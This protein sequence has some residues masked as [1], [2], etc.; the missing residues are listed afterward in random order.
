MQPGRDEML[1][2]GRAGP[3]VPR[4]PT[5]IT[6]PGGPTRAPRTSP[7]SPRPSRCRPAAAI[8]RDARVAEGPEDQGPPDGL[9]LDQ[10]IEIYV[11][12]NLD[13]RPGPGAAPGPGGRAHG[14]PARQS[15]PLRRQPAHPVRQLQHGAAR[16]P[17]PVRPEHLASHRLFPQADRRGRSMPRS[18]L[19]VMEH[20]YQDAVRR[21][22][23]DLYLAY[24][25]V[26]AAR[27]TVHYCP[28]Q[29]PGDRRVPER[30]EALY[31]EATRMSCR[32]RAGPIESAIAAVSLTDAEEMLRRRSGS[33]R[34]CSTSPPDRRRSPRAARDARGAG[35]P[36]PPDEELIQHRAGMPPG[37][38]VVPA[39]RGGGEGLPEAR[40]GQP[41]RRRVS[42]LSAVHLSEQRARSAPRARPPGRWG[43]PSPC[44]STTATRGTSSGPGSTSTSRRCS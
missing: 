38:R 39:G 9:T 19:R 40:P 43:S 36:P 21:G 23:G 17:D 11:H 2:G 44:R 3:S 4:V 28:R 8:L 42:A 10:A 20:Q 13:L 29:R 12:Q 30:H 35:P 18:S 34:P 22:I 6:M 26:L 15:D 16:R 1:F 41:V 31:R 32:R 27:R 7:A 33:W 37:R 25:N 24:V 14:Q 5:S